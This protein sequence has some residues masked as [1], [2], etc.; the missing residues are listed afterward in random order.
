MTVCD[1]CAET[2][3]AAHFCEPIDVM[4]KLGRDGGGK[5]WQRPHLNMELAESLAAQQA[6]WLASP[7]SRPRR[8]R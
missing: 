2:L 4:L 7:E 3:T 5:N 8:S 6:T 1:R